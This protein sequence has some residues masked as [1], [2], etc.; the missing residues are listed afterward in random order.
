[1]KRQNSSDQSVLLTD[2]RFLIATALS[3]ACMGVAFIWGD[4]TIQISV[5]GLLISVL[6]G[7]QLSQ[8]Q[9]TDE[10]KGCLLQGMDSLRLA[11]LLSSD[12]ELREVFEV[13]Q[14]SLS[15]VLDDDKGIYRGLATD[16]LRS[17]V[18][19]FEQVGQQELFY[20]GTE[21]W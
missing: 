4:L 6:I 9:A 21:L 5:A 14:K 10:L 3:S 2:P 7:L 18:H 17:A 1:M 15:T 16:R 8:T 12:R 13:V 19:E 20:R 11:K